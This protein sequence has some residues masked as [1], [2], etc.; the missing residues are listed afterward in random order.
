MGQLLIA[1]PGGKDQG[2][3][4]QVGKTGQRRYPMDPHTFS[5]RCDW[6][7]RGCQWIHRD[8][9]EPDPRD[10][11]ERQIEVLARKTSVSAGSVSSSS[12]SEAAH[13]GTTGG[14]RRGGFPV[15]GGPSRLRGRRRDL[16]P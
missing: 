9:E 8:I 16:G 1:V 3:S 5:R 7:L 13:P 14:E 11:L 6:C 2:S 12:D 10:R 15:T 4:E